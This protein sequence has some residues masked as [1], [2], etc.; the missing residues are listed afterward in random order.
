V[1][2]ERYPE[3]GE[4]LDSVSEL[5]GL[6]GSRLELAQDELTA[7]VH[8]A[9]LHD[10]GKIAVPDTILSKPG[11]LNDSEWQFIRQH[12]LIGERILSAAPALTDAARLV[13]ASHERIDGTGY[14]DGLAGEEIPLGARIISVC[15]AFD[16]MT[17]PRPYRASP[18]SV[19]GAIAELR[20][21]AGTQFDPRVVEV[22][23]DIVAEH[24][25]EI[26]ALAATRT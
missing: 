10:V 3:L 12:T 14:P 7:L 23:C 25:R 18:L 1:V 13:R 16:A 9:S 24:G 15:D 20:G 6:V 2:A 17:S 21:N 11:P 5:A 26:R 19:E 22:F 4:H 8:A